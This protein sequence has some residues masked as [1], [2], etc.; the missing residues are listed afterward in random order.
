LST[1]QAASPPPPPQNSIGRRDGRAACVCLKFIPENKLNIFANK[2]YKVLP[3]VYIHFAHVQ[4]SG[5]GGGG[6]LAGFLPS[7]LPSFHLYYSRRCCCRLEEGGRKEGRKEGI[8]VIGQLS[9][10][11]AAS[12]P[13]PPQNSI[14]RR[15]GRA[16]CVCLKFIPENKLNIFANKLYK[17]L[18][19]SILGQVCQGTCEAN[20]IAAGATGRQREGL[21]MREKE[22]S[23]SLYP[24]CARSDR[25]GR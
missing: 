19:G 4:I 25:G 5:G 11:Q 10:S 12:P 21:R 22:A 23:Q 13:P 3:G 6:G 18:P 17:V 16:A 1:S 15:D 24:F 14:G 7:F 20:G 2:L 8:R 9:T